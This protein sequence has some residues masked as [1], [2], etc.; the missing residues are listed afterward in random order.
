MAAVVLALA[1]KDK[2]PTN[3]SNVLAV[4]GTYAT[5]V[6]VV[7]GRNTCGNV[8][9]QSFPTNVAHTA[10]STDLVLTHAGSTYRGTVETSGRF[11]TPAARYAYPDAEYTIG[12]TGQFSTTGFTATVDLLKLADGVTCSYA[13][14]WVGTKQGS[15]NTIPG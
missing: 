4:S 6:A 2:P 12:I 13:V 5:V 7:A 1:C 14:D 3:P 8:T 15:P 9:V 11:S 10:G